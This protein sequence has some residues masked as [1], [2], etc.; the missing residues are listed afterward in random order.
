MSHWT[1]THLEPNDRGNLAAG[2]VTVAVEQ[3]SEADA[4]QAFAAAVQVAEALDYAGVQLRATVRLLNAGPL[5][6][7]ATPTSATIGA[8][9]LDL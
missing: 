8:L 9:R 2:Y 3:P 5:S 6:P 4:S 1:V 7:A